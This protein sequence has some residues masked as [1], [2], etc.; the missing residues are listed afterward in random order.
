M[1][2]NRR[3][4]VAATAA[5]AGLSQATTMVAAAVAP[6]AASL[7][8]LFL[9]G[10][11]FLGPHTVEY[12]LERGHE[13]TLFNRGRTNADLFPEL[14]RIVGDRDPEI[15]RGLAGLEDR[16]WDAVIDTSGFV[17]RIVGAS[18]AL[19]A[20][21]VRQYLFVS[22]ICTYEGWETGPKYRTEEI[23]RGT[24]AFL[25]QRPS[26]S[27]PAGAGTGQSAGGN[28]WPA[29]PSVS[30]EAQPPERTAGCLW[31]PP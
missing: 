16:Q 2:M 17:P 3:Q 25:H 20:N 31:W 30:P 11:G 8:I 5:A 24:L 21:N 15:G 14:E 18:A 12:A 7:K 6:P 9:G 10:T 29:C 23:P 22:T 26:G 28:P 4:F 19:L 1:P 27:T 13:V